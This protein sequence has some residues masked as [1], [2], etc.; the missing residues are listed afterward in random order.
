MIGILLLWFLNLVI[1]GF[2]AVG[3]G[4]TWN[5]TKHVG[6]WQHFMNWMGAIMAACG[7]TWCYMVVFGIIGTHVPMTDE[8][9]GETTMLL[10]GE[11][12]QAFFELGY[13]III[14]PIL[15]SGLSITIN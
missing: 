14:L 12:L 8:E 3:C 5:E 2:N 4:L 9:T 13:M 10:S 6:G 7:F 15:G 1:S 11:S